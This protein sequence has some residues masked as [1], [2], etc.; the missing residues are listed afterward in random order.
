M[1]EN[2]KI[3]KTKK[4][5]LNI[6]SYLLIV[7]MVLFLGVKI[8]FSKVAVSGQSMYPTL[9]GD[10]SKG[11]EYGYTDRFLFKIFGLDRYDIVVVDPPSTASVE[12]DL[13][14]KR[15]IGMPNETIQI[16]DGSVYIDDKL[17]ENDPFKDIYIEN[18]GIASEKITLGEDEY[19]V[20]GDNRNN[21][22]DSRRKEVGVF[23]YSQIYGR[24]FISRGICSDKHCDS[25]IEKHN[26]IVKGW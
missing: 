12:G 8:N 10:S 22:K 7:I 3:N 23:K 15:L 13:W 14:I 24:G 9:V 25:K 11:F 5:I 26:Y 19:F 2:K 20:M 1:E 17:L 16:K 21:S 4:I 6:L 18:S